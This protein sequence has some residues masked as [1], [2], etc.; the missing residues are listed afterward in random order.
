ME[1]QYIYC[2][3]FLCGPIGSLCKLLILIG[4]LRTA[5]RPEN[6]FAALDYGFLVH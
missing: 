4:P 6:S 3:E 5:E 2:Y 1:I